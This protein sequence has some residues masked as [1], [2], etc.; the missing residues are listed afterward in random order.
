MTRSNEEKTKNI[1]IT[2]HFPHQLFKRRGVH[3][4]FEIT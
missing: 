4:I 3:A 2:K 1:F